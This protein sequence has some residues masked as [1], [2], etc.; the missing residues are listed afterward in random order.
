MWFCP[1]VISAAP[2]TSSIRQSNS[3]TPDPQYH[4]VRS[5]FFRCATSH[6]ERTEMSQICSNKVTPCQFLAICWAFLASDQFSTI[7]TP[8]LSCEFQCSPV[9]SFRYNY[10]LGLD[11]L[12]RAHILI[13]LLGNYSFI[14]SIISIFRLRLLMFW[15]FLDSWTPADLLRF[16]DSVL[17]W[18][19]VPS[20]GFAWEKSKTVLEFIFDIAVGQSR[21]SC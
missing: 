6:H 20:I 10:M 21:F 4:I 16:H 11:F 19:L 13:S 7:H 15:T 8:R 3:H 18:I 12:A 14:R 5:L 9:D 2:C 17:L 1:Y